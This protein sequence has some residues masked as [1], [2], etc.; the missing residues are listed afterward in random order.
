MKPT[1]YV[2]VGLPALGKSTQIQKMLQMI[3]VAFVYSTDEIIERIADH[4]GKTYSEVFKDHIDS[5]HVEADIMLS[6]AIKN[7]LDVIWDQKNLGVKKRS[8]IIKKMKRAGYRVECHVMMPPTMSH[9]S[10]NVEWKW[11]LE[12]RPGK[13]I[14]NHI[15]KQ[16]YDAFVV[17]TE[18]EGFDE[19]T[20]YNMWGV[21]L[22]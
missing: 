1:C 15:M 2:M 8:K 18:E 22:K 14:P 17:P 3:P 10:D 6:D 9:I 13:E 5:A 21:V 12:S 19:I 7:K 16:M 4:I 11:R 20:L